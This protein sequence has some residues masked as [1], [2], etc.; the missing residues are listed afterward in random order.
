MALRSKQLSTLVWLVPLGIAAVS[1]FALAQ[2]PVEGPGA[3]KGKGKAKE[4]GPRSPLFFRE[5]WK[6]TPAGGEHAVDR[7]LD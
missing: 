2:Q 6:Q 1:F 5:E 7:A 3:G 4:G